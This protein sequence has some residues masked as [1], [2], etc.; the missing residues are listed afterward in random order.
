MSIV[1]A[2]LLAVVPNQLD[3]PP[4]G[5]IMTTADV[6]VTAERGTQVQLTETSPPPQPTTYAPEGLSN[7]DEMHWY[8]A[9]VG[10]PARFDQIGWRESNCRNEDGVHTSC[11]YGW[12][13]LNVGL[14][15]RDPRLAPKYR[16]CGVD[17][18]TDVN[19]DTPTD[20]QRQACATKAL[21]DTVGLSAWAAT[22]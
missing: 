8:R 10:L 3:L 7:C 11:C 1:I 20:K 15:L 18:Y 14:H 17:S 2:L 9:R 21:Y 16:A 12:W 5:V 13:Q 6:T 22:T 4:E 19:S